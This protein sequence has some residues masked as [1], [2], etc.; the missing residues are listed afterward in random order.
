MIFL[1]VSSINKTE[2]HDIVE[3]GVK[4]HKSISMLCYAYLQMLHLDN[5]FIEIA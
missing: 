3:N 5:T 4:H 1:P 2:C